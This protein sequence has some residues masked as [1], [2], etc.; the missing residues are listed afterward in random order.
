MQPGWLSISSCPF[1]PRLP[2]SAQP[3]ST[4][5]PC[6]GT[7]HCHVATKGFSV[8]LV[9]QAPKEESRKTKLRGCARPAS[10]PLS[11]TITSFGLVSWVL[12]RLKSQ[13]ARRLNYV[14]LV[15]IWFGTISSLPTPTQ[16]KGSRSCM[17][18]QPGT[19]ASGC[20]GGWSKVCRAWGFGEAMKDLLQVPGT[21]LLQPKRRWSLAHWY[22]PF[23]LIE[24]P[25]APTTSLCRRRHHADPDQYVPKPHG[26]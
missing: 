25:P 19:P 24:R 11:P 6:K 2:L 7:P 5:C 12:S 14:E 8:N 20:R 22:K 10:Q 4:A 15:T 26:G 3:P 1:K 23:C 16:K 21:I 17:A 18:A 9:E 13:D